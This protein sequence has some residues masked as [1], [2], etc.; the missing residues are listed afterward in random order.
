ME[1]LGSMNNDIPIDVLSRLHTKALL[2]LKSV[3]K[4][5]HQ[6]ISDRSFIRV[7]L[8]RTEPV[9]GFFFQEKYQWCSDDIRCISYVPV[10]KGGHKLNR[11]VFDFLPEDVTVLST[12]YG[13]FCCRSCMP[14]PGPVIYI[15][16]PSNKDWVSLKWEAPDI[17]DSLALAFDPFQDPIDISTKFKV[18]KVHKKE[19]DV[20]EN[21]YFSFEIF[22]SETG[23]WRASKE[24]CQC[25]CNLLKNKGIYIGGI[26][27]W[28][29]DSEKV[30]TFHV[31]NELSWVLPGPFPTTEF[32]SI[33]E[34]CIGESE[35][36]LNYIMISEV[37]LHVWVLEDYYES[38][39]AL[40][41]SVTLMKLEEENPQFLCGAKERVAE[42]MAIDMNAWMDPLA[43]KDGILFMRVSTSVYLYHLKTRKMEELCTISEL[44]I[45]GMFF[46]T[47]IP[48]TM[49]LVPL[50]SD[51]EHC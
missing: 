25:N 45:N 50:S 32:Q 23:E 41:F 26:L 34:M 24:I 37:G 35:G 5:W 1:K 38:K 28:L 22:Y 48:Y 9:S 2:E 49:S 12:S 31:E 21:S 6:L 27:H 14:V 29:T 51:E 46:P 10:V 44:G 33:P 20:E 11:S 19:T 18:V 17:R 39:W 8:K 36:R 42:R 15:C 4:G 30:L 13:L 7:Q 43:F 16:N 40:E 3:S 47:V